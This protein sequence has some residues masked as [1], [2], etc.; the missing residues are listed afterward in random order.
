MP[1]PKQVRAAALGMVLAGSLGYNIA[2]S[3]KVNR[4]ASKV[5]ENAVKIVDI[6]LREKAIDGAHSYRLLTLEMAVF[7][8]QPPPPASPAAAAG[9]QKN[10]DD[11]F[12]KRLGSLEQWRVKQEGGK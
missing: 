4:L 5:G 10:R 1:T 7:G 8:K 3:Q 2:L 9:W 11:E 6:D 12:R